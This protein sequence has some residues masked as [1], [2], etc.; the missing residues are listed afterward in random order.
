[1]TELFAEMDKQI[2]PDGADFESSTGY[3]RFILELFLYSSILCKENDLE[4]E[5]KYWD[6]LR[7]M[8]VY[9]RGYLRP[10]ELAPL[11]G[12]SDSGQV[13][14]IRRRRADD[15]AY[16]L[17]IGA[18]LFEDSS[19]KTRGMKMPEELLW[20]LGEQGAEKFLSLPE[21]APE[22]S[23]SFAHAGTYIMRHDDLYLCLNTSDAGLNGRGSHGHNDALSIEI[24]V[25]DRSFIVD[26]GTYVY[27]AD[28]AQ[29]HLFRS[30][31]YHSTVKIDGEEQSTTLEAVP[32]VIGN[33]AKPRVIEWE[34]KSEFD[35]VVAEHY[36]YQRL[37]SP[38][39]HRRTIVFTK[40]EKQWLIEDE[41][42]GEGEH[43]YE[44][45]F[46]FAP[47]LSVEVGETFVT[48]RVDSVGLKVTSLD[49]ATSPSLEFQATS[50]DYGEKS[51]SVSACW[52]VSGRPGKL[53]WKIE[54]SDML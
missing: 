27:T 8:L 3:H 50:S 31:A 36:G 13:L 41:F 10:D 48:A 16:V 5:K 19:L 52:R 12:D 9:M 29:R 54:I 39:T 42:L 43:D 1:M 28:L 53:R 15:H 46:H 37:P 49:V 45:R 20:I 51:D 4:I 7:S 21:G 33:E 38:V 6:K 35:R 44:V 18:A 11:I 47:G 24:C 14:P 23:E 26:P 2:L 22:V 25:G 40:A 32:F 30:T 17:A 34:T